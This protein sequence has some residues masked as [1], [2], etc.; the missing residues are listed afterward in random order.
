MDV[1]TSNPVVTVLVTNVALLTLAYRW[2][3][4]RYAG[5][6]MTRLAVLDLAM[7]ALSLVAMGLVFAG[8]G[9]RFRLVFF[10]TNWFVFTLLTYAIFEIP[11]YLSYHRRVANVGERR[12]DA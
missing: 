5:A 10:D 3:Y 2:L 11:L 9:E 8:S 4:P 7:S 12:E 6:N 1:L